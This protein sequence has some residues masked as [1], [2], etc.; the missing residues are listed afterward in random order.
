MIATRPLRELVQLADSGTWGE[1][2]DAGSGA[3]VLRSSNMQDGQLVLDDVAWRAIPSG[4][5]GRRRLATGDILVTKSSGSADHIGKCCVFRQPDDGRDYYFSNFTLRLRADS[6]SAEWRW[7]YFWLAS[8]MGRKILEALNNTT[9]GLRNLSVR[10]Y[11]EQA[12]PV[13]PLPDQ[14]RIADI[15]DKGDAVRRKR[16]EAIALTEE[17]LRSAFLEMFGDPVTNPKGWPRRPL[18]EE[19]ER[20]TVGHVGPVSEHYVDEGIPIL[21]TGNV[22]P[23]ALR[24]RN[25]LHVTRAF[26]EAHS[27]SSVKAGDVLLTRHV[28]D[29]LHCAVVPDGLGEAQCLNIILV[30]PGR[31]IRGAYVVAALSDAG[32]QQQLLGARVGTAQSVV[33]TRVLQSLALPLPPRELQNAFAGLVEKVRRLQAKH[34]AGVDVAEGLFGSLAQRA[35]RGELG[36]A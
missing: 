4:D 7:L 29:R 21:R 30:R 34:E 3:P 14:R 1:P 5:V 35:F 22:G 16:K 33:N 18:G 6:K 2:A 32:V 10:Q 28:V 24:R 17:L 25:L 13:L 20:V 27:N 26:H 8:P 15:L 23:G 11:L 9:T 31:Q 36:R 12:V 19:A